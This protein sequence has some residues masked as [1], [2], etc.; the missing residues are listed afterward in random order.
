MK[1]KLPNPT[2]LLELRRQGSFR[3]QNLHKVAVVCANIP[4]R[5]LRGVIV[6]HIRKISI[7]IYVTCEKE[8]LKFSMLSC[9]TMETLALPLLQ[10]FEI[11]FLLAMKTRYLK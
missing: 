7:L 9:V 6:S 5:L 2:Q 11:L 3:H 4:E 8:K 10:T 1:L